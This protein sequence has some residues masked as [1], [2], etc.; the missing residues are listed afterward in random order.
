MP[1]LNAL[2]AAALFALAF[3]GSAQAQSK[4]Y[5]INETTGVDVASIN[6]RGLHPTIWSIEV[7]L[8]SNEDGID[9]RLSRFEFNCSGETMRQISASGYTINGL[10]AWSNNRPSASQGIPPGTVG[11]AIMRVVCEGEYDTA[12]PFIDDPVRYT[13]LVRQLAAAEE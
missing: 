7:Y 5:P 2:M 4:W 12:F 6:R 1:K 3:A 13:E 11:S 8:A 9:Y 10:S